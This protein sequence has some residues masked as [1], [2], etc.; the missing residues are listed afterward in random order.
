MLIAQVQVE[1]I[2]LLTMDN[3]LSGYSDPVKVV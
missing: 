3:E 2:T 1:N